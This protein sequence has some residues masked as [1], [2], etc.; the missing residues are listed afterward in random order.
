MQLIKM[1][2]YNK[3]ALRLLLIFF[4]LNFWHCSLIINSWKCAV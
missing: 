2:S 1:N 3:N 4:L